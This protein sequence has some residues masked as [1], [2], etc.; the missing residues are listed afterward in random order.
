MA[1]DFSVAIRGLDATKRLMRE[2]E[3]DLLKEMNR[4]IRTQLQPV[5]T[6][7]K[8]LIPSAPPLSGWARSVSRPGSRPGYSTYNKRW[9]YA[10]LEWNSSEAKQAI[11]IR[12]GGARARGQVTSAAWKIRSNNPAAA[13]FELM[14]RGRS[15][16]NMVGNV[17]QRFPGTGRVLYRAF[18]SVGGPRIERE[19][20]GTIRKF[21]RD[22]NSRL[23]G[24]GD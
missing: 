20:V 9:D 15:R 23:Q 18:D 7:A 14:G 22:F 1:D 12:Q 4:E 11:T 3:P 2:L 24:A 10:R 5:A 17:G 19:V 16:A 21:E 6:L 13:V 8:N